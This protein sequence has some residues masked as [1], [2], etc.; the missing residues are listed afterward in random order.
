MLLMVPFTATLAPTALPLLPPAAPTAAAEILPSRSPAFW[1]DWPITVTV[2]LAVT[3]AL[4][5]EAST[6]STIWV[7]LSP[8]P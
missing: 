7:Q 2:P 3:D 6:L 1:V 8:T 4:S 5:I